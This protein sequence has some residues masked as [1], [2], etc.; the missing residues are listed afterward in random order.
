[1][2]VAVLAHG[3]PPYA[4]IAFVLQWVDRES[5]SLAGLYLAEQRARDGNLVL[6]GENPS[7][8]V[9]LTPSHLSF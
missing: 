1:M 7:Q 6:G 3:E 9:M 5:K 4:T 8:L 2:K